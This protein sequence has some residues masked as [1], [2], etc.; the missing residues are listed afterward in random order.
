MI[1][2]VNYI[3]NLSE[4]NNLNLQMMIDDKKFWPGG[5]PPKDISQLINWAI[6]DYIDYYSSY[7]EGDKNAK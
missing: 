7:K 1:S 2:I 5:I 4:I 3:I 6:Y